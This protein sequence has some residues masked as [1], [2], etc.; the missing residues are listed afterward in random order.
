[1]RVLARLLRE[2]AARLVDDAGHSIEDSPRLTASTAAESADPDSGIQEGSPGGP[3]TGKETPPMT[4]RNEPA[5]SEDVV[6]LVQRDHREIEQ[7][8][9][10]VT[11][12]AGDERKEVV[13]RLIRKLAVHET[14]EEEVVHPLLKEAGADAVANGVLHEESEAKKALARLDGLDVTE[15]AFAATFVSI[16]QDVLAHAQH[17]EREEHPVLRARFDADRLQRLG[18]RF[19]LAEKTA[20]THPHPSAPESRTGNLALGPIFAIT[21]RVRDALRHS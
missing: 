19:A 16:K 20:P 11:R 7:M 10:S 21:D 12:S 14:A 17:E 3:I 18:S 13:E 6:N 15:P 8:L 9:D 4:T 5:D 2:F 1:V